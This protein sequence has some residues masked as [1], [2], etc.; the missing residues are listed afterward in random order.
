MSGCWEMFRSSPSLSIDTA[1]Q[2]PRDEAN[3][4]LASSSFELVL[5]P[6]PFH[7]SLLLVSSYH[8]GRSADDSLPRCS[9][10]Y[11]HHRP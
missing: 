11:V 1:A 9:S 10:R 5:L 2:H 7:G 8:S 4:R 6:R 3:S